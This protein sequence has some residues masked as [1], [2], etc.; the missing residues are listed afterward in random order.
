MLANKQFAYGVLAAGILLA[1]L[2]VLID[3]LRGHDIYM[4]TS[5]II[6]LIVGLVVALAGAYLAFLYKPSA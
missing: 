6:A 1:L 4:A 3:P 5:Q 2:S